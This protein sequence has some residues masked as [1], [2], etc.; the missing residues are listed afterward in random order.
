MQISSQ[1][2]VSPGFT[3]DRT[4]A[5]TNTSGTTIQDRSRQDHARQIAQAVR[6]VNES[7]QFPVD[8]ELTIALDRNSGQPVV[9]LIDRQTREI[10][11]QIPE[12]RVL[13]IAEEF[14]RAAS[15]RPSPGGT[16]WQSTLG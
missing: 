10:I 8:N 11:Q 15:Q 16:D 1:N 5:N 14:K 3:M 7:G 9:R 2:T 4:D 13:R 6:T 12:E